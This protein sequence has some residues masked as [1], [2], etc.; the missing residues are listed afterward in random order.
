MPRKYQWPS[1]QLRD[2]DTM[3]DLHVLSKHYRVPI[4]RIIADGVR[5]Y[6]TTLRDSMDKAPEPTAPIG[7]STATHLTR[8]AAG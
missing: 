6:I 5:E 2:A 1:S 3:H 4:T 8:R 7:F